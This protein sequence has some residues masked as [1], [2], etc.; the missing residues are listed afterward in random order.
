LYSRGFRKWWQALPKD[1]RAYLWGA[2]KQAQPKIYATV[3][4][5]I[6]GFTVNY[7]VHIKEAP[8][9]GRKRF[10]AITDDQY[11]KIAQFEA[12][13][14][15]IISQLFL[16]DKYITFCALNIFPQCSKQNLPL[17]DM[18]DSSCSCKLL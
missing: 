15:R 9:T 7:M 1:R 11:L 16:R 12:D 5:I 18:S 14:V 3:A 4:V 6:L 10:I 8:I 13:L 17:D 2:F